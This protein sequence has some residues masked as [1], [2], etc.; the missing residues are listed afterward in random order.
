MAMELQ[1]CSN[2]M[3]LMC[4]VWAMRMY[5]CFHPHGTH[6]SKYGRANTSIEG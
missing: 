1:V 3:V 5:G 6:G 2:Q 4:K